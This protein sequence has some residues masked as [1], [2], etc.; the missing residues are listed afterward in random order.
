MSVSPN[1]TWEGFVGG[2]RCFFD[3]RCFVIIYTEQHVN[4]IKHFFLIRNIHPHCGLVS[5]P[6]PSSIH[7]DDVSH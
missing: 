5:K 1:K 6:L 4:L 3:T 2:G 7:M